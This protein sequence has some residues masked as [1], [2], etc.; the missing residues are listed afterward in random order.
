VLLLEY[1][2]AVDAVAATPKSDDAYAARWAD[3]KARS[4]RL[5]EIE[6]LTRLHQQSH[7]RA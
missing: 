7:R 3:L 5:D 2:A 1:D 4:E 6:R